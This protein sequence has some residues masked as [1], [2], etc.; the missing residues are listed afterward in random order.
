GGGGGA[1]GPGGAAARPVCVMGRV[2]GLSGL[3]IY[4][5]HRRAARR[6]DKGAQTGL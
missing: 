5:I 4:L 3:V 2:G 6:G 1:G